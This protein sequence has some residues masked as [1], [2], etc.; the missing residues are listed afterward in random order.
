MREHKEAILAGEDRAM[1][2]MAREWLRLEQKLEAGMAELARELAD[3]AA[4]GQIP[5]EAQIVRMERYRRLLAELRT[6][7]GEYLKWSD[8]YITKYQAQLAERGLADAAAAIRAAQADAGGVGA[9]FDVLNVKAVENM[10]GLAGDGAPL[11]KYLRQIFGDASAGMLQA[12]VDG[13]ALGMHPTKVAQLMRNGLGIGLQTA[14]NTARTESL[15]A[16]RQASLMQYRESGVVGGYKRLS[17]HDERVCAGCLMMDGTLMETLD[18][19]EEHNQGRCTAV[20]VIAGM[21]APQWQNGRDWFTE[22]SEEVQASILGSGRFEAWQNG[23]SLESMVKRVE[24]PT[25]G[26]AFVPTPVGELSGQG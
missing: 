24:D 1:R 22:Q 7:S 26:G 25:W 2:E 15:R 20:P 18:E 16:Y 4:A 6:E 5:T 8:D 17:A 9:Y 21:A 3:S 13:V 19:F 12:L 10:I 11:T 23:A 14:M